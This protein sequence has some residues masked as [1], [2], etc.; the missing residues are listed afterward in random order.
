MKQT[1]K[2]TNMSL[3]NL[4]K[5]TQYTSVQSVKLYRC[6]IALCNYSHLLFLSFTNYIKSVIFSGML[7]C[8]ESTAL[9]IIHIIKFELWNT[10]RLYHFIFQKILVPIFSLKPCVHISSPNLYNNSHGTHLAYF[11]LLNQDNPHLKINIVLEVTLL[12]VDDYS[13]ASY[14]FCILVFETISLNFVPSSA[15]SN[16]I[17]YNII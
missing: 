6:S 2:Q 1:N 11:L 16:I 10:L 9:Q 17:W 7:T 12:V 14:F 15:F 13:C 4:S 8:F 3:C 5:Y